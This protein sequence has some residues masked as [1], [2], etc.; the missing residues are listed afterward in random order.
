MKTNNLSL[1]LETLHTSFNAISTLAKKSNAT[2]VSDPIE[3]K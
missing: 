1:G 2:F 3:E